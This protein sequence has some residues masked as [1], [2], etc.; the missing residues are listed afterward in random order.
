[1]LQLLMEVLQAVAL[2]VMMLTIVISGCGGDSRPKKDQHSK[3]KSKKHRSGK[4]KSKSDKSSKRK[5]KGH[6]SRSSKSGKSK[7]ISRSKKKSKVRS[8]SSSKSL[9]STFSSKKRS[10]SKKGRSSKSDSRA[11]TSASKRPPKMV[12][13]HLS[14]RFLISENEITIYGVVDSRSISRAIGAEPPKEMMMEPAELHWSTTGGIQKVVI[15][16]PTDERRAVKV[17]C[18]DNNL[19][20]V[21]PVF[22]FIEPG[23]SLGI[24]IVR[25][26]GGAKVDKMVFV[27]TKARPEDVQPRELFTAGVANPMMVLPLIAV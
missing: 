26:N 6:S 22:S 3:S 20:R 19:Y 4:G 8:G 13:F 5:K 7:S 15:T 24:D 9:E 18:S 21:N 17:K 23:Q 12:L 1:M 2:P 11:S 14:Q 16:N 27:T 10:R 25:Q